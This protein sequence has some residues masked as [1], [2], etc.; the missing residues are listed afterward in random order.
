[1]CLD[2]THVEKGQFSKARLGLRDSFS[3][4]FLFSSGKRTGGN[5]I[6]AF[7]ENQ[8]RRSLNKYKKITEK[9]SL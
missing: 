4:G 8:A 3:A 1:M 5:K 7:T 9:V 6:R 2:V